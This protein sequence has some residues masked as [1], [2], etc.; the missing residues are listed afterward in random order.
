[1][2]AHK[3]PNPKY[4]SNGGLHMI[5]CEI[6]MRIKSVSKDK[7]DPCSEL[8]LLQNGRCTFIQGFMQVQLAAGV[9]RKHCKVFLRR[10]SK[11]D[12][13]VQ[14][15][16]LRTWNEG[17]HSISWVCLQRHGR[18]PQPERW[19]VAWPPQIAILIAKLIAM[20]PD[21]HIATLQP[22]L[23]QRFS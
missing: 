21:C 4:L 3:P 20:S 19:C 1:M 12:N 22:E 6:K 7:D 15:L 9:K 18:W 13:L 23:L 8:A 11:L 14:E 2:P 10:T 16:S 17:V 5:K